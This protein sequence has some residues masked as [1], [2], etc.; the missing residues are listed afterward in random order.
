MEFDPQ[1]Q[2]YST[3]DSSS[4]AYVS[5]SERWP[6]ILADK[7]SV[8]VHRALEGLRPLSTS[9]DLY[10]QV[11]KTGSARTGREIQV[12]VNDDGIEEGNGDDTGIEVLRFQEMC[13]IYLWG[14]A[15]DLSLLTTLTCEDLQKLQ[16][17]G[18]HQA[19]RKNV[20]SN[21]LPAAFRT[22]KN[23][24]QS[25]CKI[26]VDFV[27]EKAGS[28]LITDLIVAGYLLSTGLATMIILHPKSIPWFVSDALPVDFDDVLAALLK[29]RVF[30][31]AA[32]K[33]KIV[34]RED[35]FWTTGGSYWRLPHLAPQL[36]NEL[37][38][39]DLVIFKGELNYRKLT[40]DAHWDPITPFSGAI[41]PLGCDSGLRTLALRTCKADVIVGLAEHD[42]KCLRKTVEGDF[43][44]T[45]GGGRGLGSLP[46]RRFVMTSFRVLVQPHRV[47]S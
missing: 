33:G 43:E 13:E 12:L 14:N 42:D 39:S 6:I 24:Q 2:G 15:S 25:Q 21:N 36:S 5:V 7:R 23:T 1:I 29:P 20:L 45:C 10:V 37:E 16:G 47:F 40:S 31:A 4:F 30:F 46:L 18:A 41:G 9:E 34:V 8:L 17:A 11:F 38:T 44:R 35:R 26:R 22:L 28:E 3:S 32:E 27:L 19:Q